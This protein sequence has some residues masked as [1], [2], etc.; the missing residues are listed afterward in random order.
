MKFGDYFRPAIFACGVITVSTVVLLLA[1]DSPPAKWHYMV[2]DNKAI[3][4]VGDTGHGETGL[5]VVCGPADRTVAG[6]YGVGIVTPLPFPPGKATLKAQYAYDR[7]AWTSTLLE[8]R[9]PTL[10]QFSELFGPFLPEI[11]A[12]KALKVQ[13]G[14]DVIEFDVRGLRNYSAELRV[15][16][17]VP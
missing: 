7:E 12:A 10:G 8:V 17:I 4:V 3:F 16:G 14:A 13:V 15:C 6:K 9:E 1:A 5:G 2:V 11:L